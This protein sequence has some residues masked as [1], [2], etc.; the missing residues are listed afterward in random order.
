MHWIDPDRLPETSGVVDPCLLSAEGAAVRGRGVRPRGIAMIAA[1]GVASDAGT[2]IVDHGLLEQ[3]R[4]PGLA[5]KPA[6][7]ATEVE[8]VLLRGDGRTTRHGTVIAVREI[9]SSRDGLRRIG[10]RAGTG[11]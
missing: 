2:W 9:G 3:A 8:G 10:A 4:P 6:S 5:R 11:E 1:V 7:A